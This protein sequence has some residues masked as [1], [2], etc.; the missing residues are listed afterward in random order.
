MDNIKI[1]KMSSEDIDEILKIEKSHNV[2][3]LTKNLLVND[4]L[5]SNNYYLI[6]KY[7]NKIIGYVGISYIYDTADIIS[8]V[9]DK[10]YTNHGVATLLLNEIFSFCK[11]NNV[12]KI[13]LEVRKSNIIAQNLYLKLG[14]KKI[15][16]RKNYYEGKEDAYIY[17]KEIP[18]N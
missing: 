8:I 5:G 10:S 16:E 12:K 4:L 9:V 6:A 2:S 7:N 18:I 14:F 11:E 13:M 17:E 3:I 15:S 1:L